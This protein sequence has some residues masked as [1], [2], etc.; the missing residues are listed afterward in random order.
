MAMCVRVDATL[1]LTDSAPKNFHG[2]P[3]LLVACD[4]AGTASDALGHIEVKAV[5]LPFGQRTIRDQF[6][7]NGCDYF[8]GLE[9]LAE[10][11]ARHAYD[12]VAAVA[13]CGFMQWK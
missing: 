9:G 6:R 13:L 8:H 7:G 2:I 4:F 11:S 10:V 12:I 3:V 1:D 5:L